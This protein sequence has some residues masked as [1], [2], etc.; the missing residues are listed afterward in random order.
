MQFVAV[1]VLMAVVWGA[2]PAWT[3][4]RSRGTRV[5]GEGEASPLSGA[6][7]SGSTVA[8]EAVLDFEALQRI[9]AIAVEAS[10]AEHPL[11]D[12]AVAA[13]REVLGPLVVEWPVTRQRVLDRRRSQ[14]R[15]GLPPVP[16]APK[17]EDGDE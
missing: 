12:K 8:T 3:W 6:P 17:L 14:G 1:A 15:D 5:A 4:I 16:D 13:C 2:G 10:I 11:A 9:H 7:A